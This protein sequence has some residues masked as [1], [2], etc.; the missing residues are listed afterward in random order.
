M[1]I[2]TSILSRTDNITDTATTHK[3]SALSLAI[4]AGC[5]EIVA[6]LVV[7]EDVCVKEWNSQGM[8]PLSW[9]A[10]RGFENI[11][12]L[13]LARKDIDVNLRDWHI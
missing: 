10:H 1:R 2:V 9:A 5:E 12:A 8:T 7:R 4:D 3:R 11:F 6:L 13:L